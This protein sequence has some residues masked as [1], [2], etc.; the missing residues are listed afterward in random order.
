MNAFSVC[1]LCCSPLALYWRHPQERDL[2]VSFPKSVRLLMDLG[3]SLYLQM[4]LLFLQA[5]S[6]WT[7]WSSCVDRRFSSIL[8]GQADLCP[9]QHVIH[10]LE[11][12]LV[13]LCTRKALWV[14]CLSSLSPTT[15]LYSHPCCHT[16]SHSSF[17]VQFLWLRT[18]PHCH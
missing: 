8:P 12:R 17:M 3:V 13:L 15:S 4:S 10:H 11:T 18:H 9:K 1:H 5:Q 14:P 16:Y 2:L 6:L 7:A